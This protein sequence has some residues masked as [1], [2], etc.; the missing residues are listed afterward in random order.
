[1][2]VWCTCGKYK[3]YGEDPDGWWV[4]TLCRKPSLLTCNQCDTCDRTFRA[5][6]QGLKIAVTCPSC[7]D[8]EFKMCQCKGCNN[9]A[10]D[11]EN[12]NIYLT[13]TQKKMIGWFCNDCI[14]LSCTTECLRKK[15]A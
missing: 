5:Y 3:S 2:A 4:C 15:T 1:M 7:E 14:Q 6:K 10:L 13:E 9:I 8:V 12:D 11:F